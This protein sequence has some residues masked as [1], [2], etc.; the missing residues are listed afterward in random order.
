MLKSGRTEKYLLL[1]MV[2]LAV[3]IRIIFFVG[4]GLGDDAYYANT[5]KNFMEHGLKAL[6]TEFGSNYRFGIWI[7]LSLFY[8]FFG[9]NE[10]SFVMFPLICSLGLIPVSYLIGKELLNSRAGLTAAFMVAIC[11]FDSVFSSTMTIDIPVSF[12]CAL[13]ILLFL[14]ADRTKYP[15]FILYY[16]LSSVC[17]TWSYFIKPT[18]AVILLVFILI[19][20]FNIKSFKKHTVFYLITALL[21]SATFMLDYA[22]TGDFLHYF[23]QEMKY[24]P[25]SLDFSY[26]WQDYFKWMF[27]QDSNFGN[28]LFGYH[29]YLAVAG[30]AYCLAKRTEKIHIPFLWFIS[31]FLFFEF[32]PVSLSP[33]KIAP[34][35]FRYAHAL[36]LPG[37]LAFSMAL[38][39]FW[40]SESKKIYEIFGKKNNFKIILITSLVVISLF[41]IHE[42]YK[43]GFLYRDSF[44]DTEEASFFLSETYGP[45][46]IYSDNSMKDRFNFYTKYEKSQQLVWQFGDLEM[47]RDLIEKRRY[48]LLENV[49]NAYFISGGARDPYMSIGAISNLDEFQVPSNWVLLKEI[50]KDLTLYRKETLKIYYLKPKEGIG[51]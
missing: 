33:Y 12:L 7:P 18:A 14:R 24:G 37:I 36:V 44:S 3:F 41:S 8:I 25:K 43:T 50:E 17:V 23:N 13:G 19:S 27:L 16:F 47:Q 2:I 5:S 38:A 40:E 10:F 35:F 39:S 48:D 15:K 30:F 1:A 42:T 34:R 6:N 26:Y 11:P 51:L 20:M 45:R 32:F 28:L 31:L 49:S 21:F 29:F 4:F 46:S 9:F 22:I